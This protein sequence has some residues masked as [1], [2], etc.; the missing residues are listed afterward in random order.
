M[1]QQTHKRDLQYSTDYGHPWEPDVKAEIQPAEPIA[2]EPQYNL[3]EIIFGKGLKWYK[4]ATAWPMFILL[5]I[6]VGIRVMQTK[7]FIT[8]DQEIF[9]FLIN[10]TRLAAFVYL[11]VYGVKVLGA[12]KKQ[13][14]AA[15][16]LGGLVAGVILAVFQLFWYF[17]LW[18][19]FNLIGQPL[20]LAAQ[21]L[22]VSWLVWQLFF[23]KKN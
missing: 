1:S 10:F 23:R 11:T 14:M 20:L 9:T 18:T 17:K 2:K 6:E 5:L 22:V 12:Q 15:A 7:Y 3:G 4:E 13:I 16:A 8:T 19:F 21:G